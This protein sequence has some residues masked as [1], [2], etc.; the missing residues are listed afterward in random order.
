MGRKHSDVLVLYQSETKRLTIVCSCVCATSETRRNTVDADTC[1]HDGIDG[2]ST[3]S[4]M[5]FDV[6][7]AGQDDFGTETGSSGDGRYGELLTIYNDRLPVPNIATTS[8]I[9][10]M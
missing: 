10:P 7:S 5:S 6:S 9:N 2:I 1:T 4:N 8:V 3:V